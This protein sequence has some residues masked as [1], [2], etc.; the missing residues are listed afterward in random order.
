LSPFESGVHGALGGGTAT[1]KY[2]EAV[3][4]MFAQMFGLSFDPLRKA[5]MTERAL[6]VLAELGVSLLKDIGRYDLEEMDR[7]L[8][9][10]YM[11][12]LA[13]QSTF[14]TP[15]SRCHML[16]PRE[17]HWSSG[18]GHSA[19]KATGRLIEAE[20]LA[21]RPYLLANVV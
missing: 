7:F 3:R 19:K 5:N 6:R 11:S 1:E 10:L 4:R 8:E 17:K 12:V 15:N 18:P 13:I 16:S 21:R 2:P 9:R 14:N 20:H